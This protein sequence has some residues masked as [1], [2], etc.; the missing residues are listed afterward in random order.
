MSNKQ[1]VPLAATNTAA[2]P[3]GISV[4]GM[5]T[6]AYATRF[7]S[8]VETPPLQKKTTYTTG[9]LCSMKVESGSEFPLISEEMYKLL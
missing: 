1:S 9:I 6:D 2:D 4:R 5:L 7:V 3:H 8:L